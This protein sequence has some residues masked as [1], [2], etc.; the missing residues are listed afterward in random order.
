MK[1]TFEKDIG[2]LLDEE[3]LPAIEQA[4][5]LPLIRTAQEIGSDKRE[6]TRVDI[7]EKKF[8]L[9]F[10]NEAQF[11]RQYIENISMGGLFVKTDR[12]A[13]MGTMIPIEFSIPQGTENKTFKLNARV[14]RVAE[15][16]LGLE[17][18]NVPKSTKQELEKFVLSVLPEGVAIS[19]KAKKSTV[20]R[21]EKIRESKVD[22]IKK[23]K[24]IG[25]KIAAVVALVAVNGVLFN[26]LQE[27]KNL[28]TH[29]ADQ[30]V[31]IEDKRIQ[32]P[33]IQSVSRS[34]DGE[35]VFFLSDGTNI[36]SH[37]RSID[38]KLPYQ[39]RQTMHLL[40]S[41]P[42]LTEPRITQ[43]EVRFPLRR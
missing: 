22:S 36:Q 25:I 23:L 4:E 16:G 32:I 37:N 17:F 11:A 38:Q 13:P 30:S 2:E 33:E 41:T 34:K 42:V 29:D 8:E 20:E 9:K 3:N 1:T 10:N 31:Q 14:C 18:T 19:T 35:F 43:S 15:G 24:V 21:L 28:E 12:K 27:I 26:N 7:A 6:F 39:L 5:G 40:N